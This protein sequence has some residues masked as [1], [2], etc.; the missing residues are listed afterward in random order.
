MD[1]ASSI[2]TFAIGDVYKKR[3]SDQATRSL[4]F[5]F[6]VPLRLSTERVVIAEWIVAARIVTERVVHG[7]ATRVAAERIAA[8]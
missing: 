6:F 8:T 2:E 4:G 1:V 3:A 5:I 7:I